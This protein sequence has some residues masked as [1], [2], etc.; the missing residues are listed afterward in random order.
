M[1]M[2]GQTLKAS[3]R[4]RN[5]DGRAGNCGQSNREE[6]E[7]DNGRGV[8]DVSDRRTSVHGV[9]L[10]GGIALGDCP[11]RAIVPIPLAPI[12][13]QPLICHGL[14]WLYG[15]GIRE[16][17]I[18]ANGHS[19]PMWRDLGDGSALGMSLQYHQDVMPRGPGGC[20]RDAMTD[21]C[22]DALVV[23]EGT[24]IPRIDLRALIEAHLRNG[25]M[26]TIVVSQANRV[27]DDPKGLEPQGIYVF[28]PDALDCIPAVGYHD[29]KE[30]LIPSLYE[31][32]AQVTPYIVPHGSVRR[33]NGAESYLAVSEWAVTQITRSTADHPGYE[34][35]G[36]A[37]IHKSAT[38][39]SS[40]RLEG[41]VLIGPQATVGRDALVIGPS[42]IG[43]R[44][45]VDGRSV[46][47]RSTLWDCCIVAEGA[48]ADQCIIADGATIEPDAVVR[49]M[50]R[51]PQQRPCTTNSG[52]H[53]TRRPGGDST[54]IPE[55][56]DP[57]P[58]ESRFT[59][60][61]SLCEVPASISA[62]HQ[63]RPQDSRST[64]SPSQVVAKC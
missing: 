33:V 7:C 39:D 54:R 18:C 5:E 58:I 56:T 52:C 22:P 23:L 57:G 38:V 19:A 51:F 60:A 15:A 9:V 26:A 16:A 63:D 31:R 4:G 44:S 45:V 50:V 34:R 29:I 62:A 17:R 35:R 27:A 37:R 64:R 21:Q 59:A 8:R 11:L 36:L 47:S 28:S 3:R 48:V 49:H 14:R 40:A 42:T 46:I 24:I 30:T 53:R 6:F 12:V 43:A 55:G 61:W 32:G 2:Q 41:P 10:A 13:L 25:V 20:V 1:K